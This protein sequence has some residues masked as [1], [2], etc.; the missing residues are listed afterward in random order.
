MSQVKVRL[1][2]PLCLLMYF[3]LFFL[4]YGFI[5]LP[6]FLLFRLKYIFSTLGR[7]GLLVTH[8]ISF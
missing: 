8:S 3:P 2:P 1:F 5:L 4:V 6:G 7:P